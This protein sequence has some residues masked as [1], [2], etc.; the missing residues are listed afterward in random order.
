MVALVA[1]GSVCLAK[2]Q[3]QNRKRI[4]TFHDWQAFTLT[5]GDNTVCYAI[6]VPKKMTPKTVRRNGRTVR[7]QRG[8]V[9]VTITHRPA[10]E[11]ENEVNVVIGY[12]FKKRSQV[13]YTID[14][15]RHNLFT[16]DDGAWAYD[17]KSDNTIVRAMERGKTLVVT[18]TS[19][20]GTTTKD[21]YSLVGFT[22]AHNAIDKACGVK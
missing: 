8:E 2:G 1:S 12:P 21:T 18:G 15:H 5:T 10:T 17:S 14:G 22:A 6:S 9:Y 16:M 20:H 13:A 3:D 7:L 11:T 4:G 19:S